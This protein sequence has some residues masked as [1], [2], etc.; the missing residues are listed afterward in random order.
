MYFYKSCSLMM[1]IFFFHLGPV[2][3]AIA[4]SSNAILVFHIWAPDSRVGYFLSIMMSFSKPF[5][6]RDS[7]G[8]NSF[9]SRIV[10]VVA[11]K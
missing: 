1:C 2:S 4:M 11:L 8:D 5:L 9:V 7:F 6:I 10:K 3:G